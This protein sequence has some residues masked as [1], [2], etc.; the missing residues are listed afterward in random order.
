M[1]YFRISLHKEKALL[2]KMQELDIHEEDLRESFV[3]ASGPGGQKVNKTSSCVYLKHLPTGIEVKCQ[4][5]RSQVLNRYLARK[6]LVKKIETLRL[7]KLTQEKQ[8]K[9]KIRRQ[10][11]GRSKETKLRILKEKRRHAEKKRLR[12]KIRQLETE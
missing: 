9:E 2:K 1:S 10:T 5:E 6:L 12:A 4:E 3:R 8:L 11:R 7:K